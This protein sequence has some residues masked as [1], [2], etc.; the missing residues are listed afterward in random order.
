[1]STPLTAEKLAAIRERHAAATKGP[2]RWFG[3]LS[4]ADVVL[5]AAD[6]EEVM[7]FAHMGR[8]AQP[9][10]TV[11]SRAR[12]LTDLVTPGAIA[13]S[14]PVTDI[15]HPDARFIAASWEDVRDLLAHVATLE[16]A[17]EDETRKY[18]TAWTTLTNTQA[19]LRAAEARVKA[20]DAQFRAT[21][22]EKRAVEEH[23]A[24]LAA[25][26]E[27]ADEALAAADE[28]YRR[29]PTPP[30]G[31]LDL[32]GDF[33]STL[34][35]TPRNPYPSEDDPRAAGWADAMDAVREGANEL[36]GAFNAARAGVAPT[37]VPTVPALVERAGKDGAQ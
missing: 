2:W 36:G 12:R 34:A 27:D 26:L 3:W 18:K 22:R 7:S 33:L 25:R 1:M 21:E 14:E 5:Q 6:W 8:W 13:G 32:L 24:K 16:A 15:N 28:Q 29:A 19:T 9:C 23:A 31:L 11:E 10:F 17:L 4:S 35:S 20:L 37:P 30:P